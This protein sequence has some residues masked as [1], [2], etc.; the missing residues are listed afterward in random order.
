MI[1]LNNIQIDKES[2]TLL[3]VILNFFRDDFDF[4]ECEEFITVYFND[5]YFYKNLKPKLSNYINTVDH[6]LTCLEMFKV[7]S[8][9]FMKNQTTEQFINV[10]RF[11]YNWYDEKVFSKKIDM[12]LDKLHVKLGLTGWDI[13]LNMKMIILKK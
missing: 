9:N 6:N 2:K 11:L 5:Y 7:F 1:F 4:E 12:F 13:M 8:D 10:K 3:L